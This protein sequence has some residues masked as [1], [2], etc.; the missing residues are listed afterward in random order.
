LP[1]GKKVCE[2]VAAMRPVLLAALLFLLGCASA[3]EAV[4]QL[5]GRK[6]LEVF[7][8]AGK[9][10]KP[11]TTFSSDAPRIYA[12]WKGEKL[13]VGDKITSVWI[14]EDIG[15]AGPKESKILEGAG[16]VYKS[17]DE[18][19]FFLSRPAYKV[20]PV[21]K[22]RVEIHINGGLAN[23]VKFTIKPGVTIEAQ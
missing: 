6:S 7:L 18:G 12:F 22:Y 10:S 21:G 3:V 16:N 17:N 2:L 20:W 14:A 13:A 19:S 15:D 9:D 23:L 5:G 4:A 1:N 8:S 11:T